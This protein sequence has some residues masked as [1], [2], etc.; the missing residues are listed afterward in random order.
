[1]ARRR[2]VGGPVPSAD[3]DEGNN[4]GQ[5]KMQEDSDG[6]DSG[7]VGSVRGSMMMAILSRCA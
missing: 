4:G 7:G 5:E 1:M 3:G 6:A 2:T